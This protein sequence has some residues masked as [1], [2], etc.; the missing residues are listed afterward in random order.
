MHKNYSSAHIITALT[1]LLACF[2]TQTQA[3]YRPGDSASFNKD[4]YRF[5]K[6][7]EVK[8]AT[9]AQLFDRARFWALNN[10]RALDDKLALQDENNGRLLLTAK[11][12]VPEGNSVFFTAIIDVQNEK[13]RVILDNFEFGNGL[14]DFIHHQDGGKLK[15]PN[16]ESQQVHFTKGQWDRLKHRTYMS[17]AGYLHSLE[18]VLNGRGQYIAP[19]AR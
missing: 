19:F 16:P 1:V 4:L 14:Y 2:F 18:E 10:F 17:G 8:G 13:C 11:M 3:Q 15:N 6:L 7:I 9:K 5:E 12:Q